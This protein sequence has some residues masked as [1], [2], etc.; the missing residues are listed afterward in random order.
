MHPRIVR[1]QAIGGLRLALDFTDGTSG[2]VDLAPMIAGHRGVFEPF[3]DPGFF[4]QVSVDADAG[5]VVWP[6]GVDLDPDVLYDAAQA[7]PV[8]DRS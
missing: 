2:V 5:T 3:H 6:N 1:A 7:L 8:G 4:A